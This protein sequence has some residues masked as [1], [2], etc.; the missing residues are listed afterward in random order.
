[1]PLADVSAG[2]YALESVSG[3]TK[4][5]TWC[6]ESRLAQICNAAAFKASVAIMGADDSAFLLMV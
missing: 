2:G 4:L 3:K 1:V 5:T 6:P